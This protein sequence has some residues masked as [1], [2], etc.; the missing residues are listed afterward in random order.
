MT[1]ANWQWRPLGDLFDIGAGKT[2]SEAARTGEDK[3]PFLRTSNVFWDEIDLST[4][5]EMSM[6]PSELE[7]KRLMRGDLLVC[8]GGEIGRA[9]VWDGQAALMSFQNHLHRLRPLRPDVDPRFYVYFL[10]SAFTQLGIFEGAGNKTTIPNLSRNRLAA[11]DVPFPPL[12]EQ[13]GVADALRSIRAAIGLQAKATAT[14]AELKRTAM[15]D[16]FSRGLNGEEQKETEIG[17]VPLSWSVLA[18]SGI[19]DVLSTRMSYSELEAF[20]STTAGDSLP[21]L[22]IK[23]S[24]MNRP[25]NEVNLTHAA[26]TVAVARDVAG[27]RCAPPGT[28]I[29]PKR[30]A[31]IATNKKRF[32]TTWTVFDP[33]V[34]GVRARDG[35]SA[36]FL[37]HWF[38]NFD[39]RTITEPG[40]TPQL[41]K[42]NLEPLLVPVP[43]TRDEQTEIADV[44]DAI[45]RKIDMHRR[46]HEVLE[47][48][49]RSLLYKLMIGEIGVSQLNLAALANTEPEAAA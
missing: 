23:V 27:R 42:K 35:L 20:P 3:V 46:K 13:R 28:I 37:F 47:E 25:G 26:L 19:A 14:A 9:A 38:Q 17:P 11:L 12:A 16:L 34:I 40:P 2:M 1:N 33:N 10:Q 49:F 32:S 4:V 24:D 48:L 21:V 18:L 39:L 30:G 5:D 41:N 31:A 36:R 29:F 7:D 15:R 6:S 8:E 43:A 44:F 22:G 45:D